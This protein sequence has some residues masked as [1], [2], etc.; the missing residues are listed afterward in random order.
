MEKTNILITSAGRRVSLVNSFLKE[1]KQHSFS[2]FCTDME[3]E[4]SS[5][6]LVAD[7]SFKVSRV[8]DNNYINELLKICT[9]NNVKVIIPTI[10]TELEFLSRKINFFNKYNISVIVSDIS[11]IEKCR[12]KRLIHNLFDTIGLRRAKEYDSNSFQFPLFIK[13][14]DGSRS[15][16]IHLIKTNKDLSNELLNNKKNMFLEYFSPKIYN[17]F[18]VDIY[19]NKYSKILSVIPRERIAVRDGEVSKA[20]TRKNEIVTLVREKFGNLSGLRGC[21]TL[22]VFKHTSKKDIIGIE[23]NPRFGGGFPLSYLSGAN[24][25]KWIIEEYILD[26]EL[27]S[28]FDDWEDNL[29]MLRYDAEILKYGY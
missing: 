29:L 22:Q 8:S 25:P 5:A 16:G 14:F 11:F 3:P 21:I 19:F 18:T 13:P 10:D 4:L 6:C 7:K 24:F 28:Y 12:N 1:A 17:E 2:V 27:E 26:N 20:C 23:V 15:Q 9:D